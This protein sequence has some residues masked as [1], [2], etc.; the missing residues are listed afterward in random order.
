MTP[1][2]YKF[3]KMVE[4]ALQHTPLVI[5]FRDKENNYSEKLVS[6]RQ[7]ANNTS[8]KEI[9]QHTYL[10]DEILEEPISEL[11]IEHLSGFV[12]VKEDQYEN[13]VNVRKI[14]LE[15]AVRENPKVAKQI[16]QTKFS[17]YLLSFQHREICAYFNLD[18]TKHIIY[19][20]VFENID[21]VEKVKAKFKQ[22]IEQRAGLEKQKIALEIESLKKELD[23]E[24]YQGAIEHTETI[25]EWL[26]NITN[27]TNVDKKR[28]VEEILESWPVVFEPAPWKKTT[29]VLS[30][31]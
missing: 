24:T 5:Y 21:N 26:S 8:T 28:N 1:T 4:D 16:L 7:I 30:L 25:Y 29:D 2:D 20:Q 10:Y 9:T 13:A 14:I 27:E 31:I 6:L 17:N 18:C 22:K 11:D 15:T 19:K 23:E 12:A 3:A